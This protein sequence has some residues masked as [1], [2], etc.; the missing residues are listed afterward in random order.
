[1]ENVQGQPGAGEHHNKG[2]QQQIC[3]TMTIGNGSTKERREK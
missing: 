1:V 3:A 2:D